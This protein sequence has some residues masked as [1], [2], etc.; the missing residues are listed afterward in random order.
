LRAALANDEFCLYSQA[1]APLGNESREVALHEVLLRMNEE[2][3]NHLPPG[4]FLPLAEELGL[5][6]EVDRWVIRHIVD[7]AAG[8]GRGERAVYL[9]NLA[10]PTVLDAGFAPFVRERLEAAGVSGVS[11]CFELIEADVLARPAAYR[12]FIGSFAGSGCRFAVSGFGRNPLA[13]QLIRK[14]GVDFLKLDAGLVLSVL[15]SPAALAKVKA[16]N[17]AAHA[18]G[19][20]TIAECVENDT[21]RAALERVETDFAQGFGVAQPRLMGG[22]LTPADSPANLQAVA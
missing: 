8:A 12:D 10:G 13:L 18:A 20:R 5:L 19:M 15:R 1:I 6:H 11:L 14:L 3:E 21:T 7:Y 2:E 17:K 4:T 9:V 22:A 16:V